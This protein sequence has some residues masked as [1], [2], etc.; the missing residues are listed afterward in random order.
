GAWFLDGL[1]D[2][3]RR[4]PGEIGQVDGL[5]L[6]LRIEVCAGDGF[7]PNAALTERIFAAGLKGRLESRGR[8]Y[9]LVLDVG[10]YHKN[11]FTLA[12]SFAI[13]REEISLAI[14]LLDQLFRACKQ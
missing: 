12:P 4:H 8:R 11:V 7:T 9:G 10:G 6:A 1:R 5:G 2:L 3:Q 13:S 14:D